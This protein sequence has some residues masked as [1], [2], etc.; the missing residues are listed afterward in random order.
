MKLSKFKVTEGF[1]KDQVGAFVRHEVKAVGTEAERVVAV[2][3][4]MAGNRLVEFKPE[5][6]EAIA[7]E[8]D[9]EAEAD[10]E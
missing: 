3:L 10:K 2:V 9:A 7:D 6:V 1:W 8:P 4:H 5:H